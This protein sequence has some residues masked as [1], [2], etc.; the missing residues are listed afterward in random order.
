MYLFEGLKKKISEYLSPEDVDLVQK[1]Y[2]VSVKHTR[3]RR[4]LAVS[5][6]SLTQ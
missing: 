4:A 3:D 2:V 1:A 6:I 5:P